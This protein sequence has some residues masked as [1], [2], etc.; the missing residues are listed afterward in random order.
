MREGKGG[1]KE[2]RKERERGGRNEKG[3]RMSHVVHPTKVTAM[4]TQ[5]VSF[6][7]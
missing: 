5:Q 4:N 2:K 6:V 1:K 3:K 7:F